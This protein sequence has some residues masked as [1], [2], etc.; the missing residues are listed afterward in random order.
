MIRT[1][2]VDHLLPDER[3]PGHTPPVLTVSSL[4]RMARSL[5]EDGFPSVT[6]EAE[7]S[8]LATPASGHWYL[9]LK[10]ERAQIRCAMFRNR[11]RSVRFRPANG[12][13]VTVR[14][15]LSLYEARGDYQLILDSME[16]AGAGALQRAFEA[17]KHRLGDEGLFNADRKRPLPA[18]CHHVGVIT[19]RTGAALQDIL[20]VFNRRFPLM[21][22]TVFPVP[23]QGEEAPAAIVRALQLANRRREELHLDALLVGRGGGSLEDLQAF[24][25]ESVA[26]A[27][28]DSTLPVVSAVGHETD[29]SISD[30]VADVRA[31][32]PTAAAE[33]MSPDGAALAQRFHQAER[34]LQSAVRQTLSRRAEQVRSLLRRLRHPGRQLQE[35][36]QRL[37]GLEQ[38]L[39]RALRQ[40]IERHRTALDHRHR[41]LLLQDPRARIA[42]RKE[43]NN[44]L[45]QRLRRAMLDGLET[46][47]N[48]LEQLGHTLDAVSPLQTLARGYS[49]TT[50]ARGTLVR[51]STALKPGDRLTTRLARGH[52]HSIV[53]ESETS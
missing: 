28:A 26:R 3:G 11:N 2:N 25:E 51:D 35:Q 30:F 17:L 48:R 20:T 15:R 12:M 40:Q 46:R 4:N 21:R 38:R 27:I 44:Q 10:D 36:A 49:I 24:N 31:P 8:N 50:D 9:T 6:V 53:E 34:R 42:Q 1:M 5:L 14:G 43:H 39:Q 13:Q 18:R 7:I 19:S 45:R 29:T 47:R 41:R 37:D 16:E 52:V 23:V 32:T 33:L 22:I